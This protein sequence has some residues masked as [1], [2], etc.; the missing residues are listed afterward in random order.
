MK[1]EELKLV[2]R[3]KRAASSRMNKKVPQ[4]KST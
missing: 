1:D 2:S 3:G 4:K